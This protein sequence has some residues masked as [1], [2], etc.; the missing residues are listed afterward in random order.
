MDKKWTH[1][2]FAVGAILLA[3]VFSK[4]GEWVW[5]YFG[6][7][8]GMMLGGIAVVLA[9]AVA[10]VCWQNEEVFG[11]AN[12]AMTELSKVTWPS[13]EETFNSTIIVIITTIIASIILGLFDGIWSWVTRL[14]Y[15]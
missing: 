9:G 10:W 3:W 15:G 11:L 5:G 8:N 7:P 1:V 14:I 12:E 4:T 13:R 2:L 6:K